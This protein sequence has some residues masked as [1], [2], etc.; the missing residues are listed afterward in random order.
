MNGPENPM[1]GEP[2]GKFSDVLS[3]GF[4]AYIFI[5]DFGLSSSEGNVRMH[6]KVVAS[7][8][9]AKEFCDLLSQSLD[10]YVERHGP[11]R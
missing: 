8:A 3:I 10:E 2:D 5:F 6:T 1:N 4:N 11:L 7:P 9:S